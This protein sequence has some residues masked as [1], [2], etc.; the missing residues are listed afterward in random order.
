MKSQ[1]FLIYKTTNL[2]NGKIYIGKHIARCID[3]GYMGSGKLLK[4]AISKYGIENFV[5]EILH[6]CSSEEEMNA[7]EA[8]I[9]T[10]EFCNLDTNYNLCVGGQGGFSYINRN[11]LQGF[12]LDSN[13]AK[14][15]RIEA[16]KNGALIKSKQRRNE[17]RNDRD[18]VERNKSAIREGR[19]KSS[20]KGS[21]FLGKTHTDQTKDKM[22]LSN[23]RTQKVI[24]KG[25]HY[26]SLMQAYRMTGERTS[27]IS[28]KIRSDKYPDYKKNMEG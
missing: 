4:R 3:D 18:W 17:L 23:K 7:K 14:R 13:L 12:V 24:I 16:N 10:E 20:K 28:R 25:I 26:D 21:S 1:H 15:G 11:D 8:E 2:I 22:R 9:V 19:A 5:R 27:E 6:E